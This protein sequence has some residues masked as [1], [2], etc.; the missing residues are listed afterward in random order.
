M[1]QDATVI[2]TPE[3]IDAYRMLALRSGLKLEVLGMRKR[4]QSCLSIIK[5]EYGLKGS[6][7]RV[8]EQFEDLLR[9]QGVIQ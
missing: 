4:G 9:Q 3:G 7:Q 2:D 8:L 5:S 1:S 6:K